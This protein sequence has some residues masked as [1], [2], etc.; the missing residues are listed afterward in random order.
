[1]C[2]QSELGDGGLD[3]N[4]LAFEGE[5]EARDRL[6]LMRAENLSVA[7]AFDLS[8]ADL[9][10]VPQRL[11]RRLGLTVTSL[12]KVLALGYPRRRAWRSRPRST[13]SS[14]SL[15]LT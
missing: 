8:Y 5:A 4:R 11:F 1:V 13:A 9:T 3:F 7:A 10:P 15:G 14:G 12:A 6:G 2:G